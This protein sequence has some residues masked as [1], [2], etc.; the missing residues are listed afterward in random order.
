M[1]APHVYIDEIAKHEG[2]PVEL[3]GWLYNRRSSGKLHFLEV[4]DGTGIIQAVVFVKDVPPEI[5]EAAGK[6]PQEA[7]IKVTGTVKKDPRSPIG[8][9]LGVSALEIVSLPTQ[10]YPIS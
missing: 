2:Q 7:A 9:E 6:L 3:R 10:E 5:F 8:Y 4:R 1:S